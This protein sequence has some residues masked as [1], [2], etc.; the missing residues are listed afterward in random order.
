MSVKAFGFKATILF[1]MAIFIWF[2]CIHLWQDKALGCSRSSCEHAMLLVLLEGLA[3]CGQF[4]NLCRKRRTDCPCCRR[5]RRSPWFAFLPR[6]P[7]VWQVCGSEGS[8]QRDWR[9]SESFQIAIQNIAMTRASK[10]WTSRYILCFLFAKPLLPCCRF[11]WRPSIYRD[12]WAAQLLA[13]ASCTL[14]QF[15]DNVSRSNSGG[16]C[17]SRLCQARTKSL[18]LSASI[19]TWAAIKSWGSENSSYVWSLFNSK[20]MLQVAGNRVAKPLPPVTCSA[21]EA[22]KYLNTERFCM[23]PKIFFQIFVW[24]E[25]HFVIARRERCLLCCFELGFKRSVFV[26]QTHLGGRI[27]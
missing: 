17:L 2:N 16:T 23:N 11:G 7:R 4:I 5:S 9:Y 6:P 22:M 21:K 15:T 13:L 24:F 25:L 14:T 18:S 10:Q 3:S 1:S 12:T 19:G 26:P 20:F 27:L 8:V